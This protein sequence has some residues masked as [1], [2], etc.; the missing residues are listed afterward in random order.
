MRWCTATAHQL[1]LILTLGYVRV[2]GT[3]E[4]SSSLPWPVIVQHEA[5]GTGPCVA[6]DF[7]LSDD[8]TPGQHTRNTTPQFILR[9]WGASQLAALHPR[10][11]DRMLPCLVSLPCGIDARVA[12]EAAAE[13]EGGADGLHPSVSSVFMQPVALNAAAGA[14]LG[15]PPT[16]SACADKLTQQLL[17]SSSAARPELAHVLHSVAARAFHCLPGTPDSPH[18]SSEA[19]AHRG[20]T[21]Q[22]VPC[23]RGLQAAAYAA[24]YLPAAGEALQPVLVLEHRAA[25]G[26]QPQACPKGMLPA[27]GPMP[28]QQPFQPLQHPADE[29][30]KQPCKDSIPSSAMHHC[31][32]QQQ[33]YDDPGAGLV[34]VKQVQRTMGRTDLPTEF[35]SAHLKCSQNALSVLAF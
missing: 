32:P 34:Y 24:Y 6:V 23:G 17:A 12:V 13:L 3:K 8:G 21:S 35:Q 16:P 22:L 33:H 31:Q 18:S 14:L 2:Q 27:T 1:V 9:I 4:P 7:S 11:L 20:L 30:S 19:A 26:V 15:C 25:P 10:L 28:T 5:G 29:S